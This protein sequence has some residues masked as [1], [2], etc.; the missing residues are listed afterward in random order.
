MTLLP[1][2]LE[3]NIWV[4]L[5]HVKLSVDKPPVYEAL[6][7]TW[8]SPDLLHGVNVGSEHGHQ[9]LPI[10]ENLYV[11]LKYLRDDFVPRTLWVDAT[12]I[13]QN[14]VEER[15]QQVARMADI[16][17]LATKVVIWLGPKA[18]NST[19]AIE[20]L[21]T[22]ASKIEVDWPHYTVTPTLVEDAHSV[23]LDLSKHAPFDDDTWIA[24]VHLLNRPWFSRLWIW[25]EVFLAHNGAEI[26]C[27]QKVMAWEDFRKAIL[28]LWRR[29]KPDR[30]E[31]LHKV[32]SRAWKICNLDDQ[33]SLR[34]ILR[35]TKGAQCSDQRD[36]IYGVLN[37]V[38]EQERLGLQP[39]YN[40]S[41]VEVFRDLMVTSIF[42]YWDLSL[43]SC[44]EL[45]DERAEMPTWV[46][47]WS[48]PRKCNEIWGATAC[49]NSVPS[50]KYN[51][52]DGF[53][54]VSGCHAA[55]IIKVTEILQN[56]SSTVAASG[57]VPQLHETYTA[58]RRLA[59]WLR[60]ELPVQFEQQIEAICRTLCCNEFSDRYEPINDMHLD[61]RQTVDRF[62]MLV[63]PE[64]ESTDAFL[65]ECAMFLDAFYVNSLGRSFIVTEES[66]VGLA[67]NTCRKD[68]CI[69]V[70]LGCQSPIILRKKAN[71]EYLVIGECYVHGLMTGEAFL[72]PLPSKWQHVARYDDNTQANWYAFIDRAKAIWQVEDPRLGPLPDDWAEEKH[73]MQHIYARFRNLKQGWASLYDPRM[74][75]AA[76]RE[77]GVA[78]Q[79]FTLV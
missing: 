12:C 27:G 21:E 43:L 1:G 18:G 7:Y 56:T 37:L 58:V 60:K 36:R 55:T 39:D 41:V 26:I 54:I 22:I 76:L 31:G 53:L 24:I 30:I 48:I 14:D 38:N 74:M 42:E 79:D 61:L 69:A 77:R 59:S 49:W 28:S 51:D 17:W 25:Q 33:P 16:Y 46:P 4:E 75:L 63:D 78:L 67:P 52:G 62:I 65:K 10:T 32:L 3:S 68:D 45:Q 2:T 19:I 13:N 47:N 71:G 11:A 66:Y 5:S 20:A 35:R 64:R 15:G 44:C 73:P 9:V 70:I 29:R 72:G 50:A 6:S 23:W 8:G 40:K 57:K 34:T